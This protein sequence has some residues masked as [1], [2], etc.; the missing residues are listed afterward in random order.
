VT[1]WQGG[2]G[3]CKNK[4]GSAKHRSRLCYLGKVARRAYL[5][6]LRLCRTSATTLPRCHAALYLLPNLSPHLRHA[7]ASC[8]A[9]HSA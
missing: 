7:R 9:L 1:A 6:L 8:L 2:R 5:P 4:R 3:I